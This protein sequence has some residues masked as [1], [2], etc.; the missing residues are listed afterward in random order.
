[1]SMNHLNASELVTALIT[2]GVSVRLDGDWL[3]VTGPEQVITDKVKGAIA[4]RKP[5]I[6][7]LLR[8]EK[9]NEETPL[10]YFSESGDLVIPFD[11]DP[12]YFWWAGRQSVRETREELRRNMVN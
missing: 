3:K 12:K 7:S 10:P 4:E 9:P 8:G 1:M 6:T 11:A 5:E 2:Q